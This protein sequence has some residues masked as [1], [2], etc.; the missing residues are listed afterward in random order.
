MNM[1]RTIKLRYFEEQSGKMMFYRTSRSF[2]T[3]D[4]LLIR[5]VLIVVS[6]HIKPL[7]KANKSVAH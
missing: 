1:T 4:A 6:T 7:S 2:K 5:E 3:E